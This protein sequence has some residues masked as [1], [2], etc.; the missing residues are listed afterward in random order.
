M[1]AK[2]THVLT[3]IVVSTTMLYAATGLAQT[4]GGALPP[5]AGGAGIAPPGT[6]YTTVSG[7]AGG[8]SSALN[9][10]SPGSMISGHC[11][12]PDGSVQTYSFSNPPCTSAGN[13]ICNTTA[14]GGPTC[15]N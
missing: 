3:G 15:N 9:T 8:A 13:V 1:K 14:N 6:T 4:F 12:A 2:F 10:T 7:G 11:T 5:P